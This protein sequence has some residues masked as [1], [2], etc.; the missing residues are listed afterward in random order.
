MAT[1]MCSYSFRLSSLFLFQYQ[2]SKEE[3]EIENFGVSSS[4]IS[5]SNPQQQQLM[6]QQ[7]YL[8]LNGDQVTISKRW[9]TRPVS[10]SE[11]QSMKCYIERDRQGFS[12]PTVYRCYLESPVDLTSGPGPAEKCKSQTPARLDRVQYF[13][14]HIP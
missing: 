2:L 14:D 7:Q 1:M 11:R 8:S 12:T 5:S 13:I 4:R 6:Q 9:L 3:Q 10:K